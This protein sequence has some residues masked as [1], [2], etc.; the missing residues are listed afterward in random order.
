LTLTFIVDPKQIDEHQTAFCGNGELLDGMPVGE[1]APVVGNS[2]RSLPGR[3]RRIASALHSH[4]LGRRRWLPPE[5]DHLRRDMG[6]P[7]REIRREYW[8]Y[9]WW[10]H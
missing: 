9:Y 8:D 6:L 5:D 7:E 3:L 1:P 10:D 2:G 4:L